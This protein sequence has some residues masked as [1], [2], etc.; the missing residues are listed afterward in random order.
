MKN[1]H[2]KLKKIYLKRFIRSVLFLLLISATSVSLHAQTPTWNARQNIKMNNVT[3]QQLV[4]NLKT[5]FEFSFFIVDEQIGKT[6]V[7]V[8]LKSATINE[9]LDKAFQGKG[10]VYTIR[11]KNITISVKTGKIKH[12]VG[13]KGISGVITDEKGEPVYGASI[14]EEGAKTGTISD[15]DGWFTIDAKSDGKLKVSYIGYETKIVAVNNNTELKIS[16][17]ENNR[18]LNEVVVVGYGVQKKS[19]LTGSIASIDSKDLENVHGGSTVSTDLAG[20]IAGVSFREGDGRPGASATIQIRNMGD[21]LYV[22]DGIQEDAGQFNNLA[23][24]DIESITVLKDASAAIYGVKAANGVVVVTTKRGKRNTKSTINVDAYT[25][26]QNWTTYPKVSNAYQWNMGK[27]EADINQTGTTA[28]TPAQLALYKAGTAPGYQSFDWAKFI[29]TPN[30]PQNSVNINATGGSDKINYYLSFTSLDQDAVLKEFKFTR[31]NLQSNVDANITKDLKVG[32]SI[33]GRIESRENPGVPGGDDYWEP[34]FA[35]IRNTP[36]DRPY[37]NDNPLYL[38][39]DGHVDDNFAMDNEAISGK[40]TNVW[41]VLQTNFN[42]EYKL[43]IKGLSV[44]GTY[45]YYYANNQ[46]NNHE[47]TFNAYTY[48]PTTKT[49]DITG[50]SQNPW[51]ERNTDLILDNVIRG[52]INYKNSFGLHNVE[53]VV[54]AERDKRQ[55]NSAYLHDVPALNE[56]SIVQF[57]TMDTYNDASTTTARIGYIGRFTYNY[58]NKYYAEV[59][60]RRD[61]SSLFA[62]DKRWGFFPSA[63]VGW[64]P[65]SEKF[66]QD[67]TN[68]KNILTDLK[69]RASYG[70]LG[71]DNNGITA[72]SFVYVP[73]YTYPSGSTAIFNGNPVLGSRDRGLQATNLTWYVSRIA[74]VGADFSLFK[75]KLNG[76]VDYFYRKRTG[77]SGQKNDVLIPEE[78]GFSLPNENVNSDA[79]MGE[80]M[81]LNYSGKIDKVEY[82]IGANIS[83]SRREDLNTYNP[84]FGNSWDQ[85]RNSIENRYDGITWGYQVIGQFKSQDQINNYK[86]NMDGQGNKTL[87]PGDLIFKDQNGDG[88]INQYDQRPIG[89]PEG[90]QPLLNGGLQLGVKWHGFDLSAQFSVGSGYTYERHYEMMWPFQN[91]GNLL[92]EFYN[93][94]WH[95]T[96][97]YDVNSPWVAGMYPALRFNDASMSNYEGM[98]ATSSFWLTSVYYLRLRTLELGYSLPKAL[99]TKVGIQKVRFFVNTYNLFSIDNTS[100]IGIDP[101]V[102]SSNG[103][104]YP[105]EMS[106][107]IGVNLSF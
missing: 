7:S 90:Q 8:D 45:S 84:M 65:T 4:D 87:L 18:L 99:L 36:M 19:D 39:N 11:D 68:M 31:R 27:V 12:K 35:I 100:G 72:S 74:D 63:S 34:R 79:Q 86:V 81:V 37:A 56:L 10:I 51:Q 103:M 83:Y 88:V 48:N 62:P 46:L 85:Y 95:H 107:N 102:T 21:P 32:V 75:G 71:D 20:K 57:A 61:A 104:D 30:M 69:F 5:L 28:I 14:L 9:I 22:I 6:T 101:E 16:L 93:N 49:Y 67:L 94:S 42:A 80:E 41:Y 105:Q 54:A 55:E 33:N 15:L 70:M 60:A 50:G 47:Y 91:G 97:P 92:Q 58:G 96:N 17:V 78:A 23:P 26:F 53:A 76:S 52:E 40:Y 82:T 2:H 38:N 43:P 3:V 106:T 98:G 64:R 66:Y 44:K 77:L 73:G 13:Q 89:L 24:N 29:I 1:N 59:S 25:G